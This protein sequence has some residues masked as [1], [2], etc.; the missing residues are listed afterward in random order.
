MRLSPNYIVDSENKQIAV[1]IDID[2]YHKIEETLEN[3]ALAKFI[4]EDTD[5]ET[6]S[7]D[8][9]KKYYQSLKSV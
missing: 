2:T 7:T 5:E 1:Q 8:E 3:Y 9:A 6:L 4:D